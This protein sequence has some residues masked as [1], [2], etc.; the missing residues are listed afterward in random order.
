MSTLPQ[1]LTDTAARHGD[2]PAFKLDDTGLTYAELD[3]A[4]SRV[5]GLLRERG[6]QPG[7]RVGLMLPNVP[8]FP[9]IYY[10]ILRAGGVVV[11]MNV[12]LKGRE[13]SFYL[14]DPGAKHLFAWHDFAAAAE[15][16]AEEAGAE[17]IVVKPGE[18]ERLLADAPSTP[19]NA[20]RD[21]SDTAIILYTSGTT[22]TPKGAELTHDN[23]LRNAEVTSVTL[24]NATE[25]DVVLGALPLF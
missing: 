15:Q 22:G 16:G 20:E 10:G 3:A 8:Y 9:V 13:V 24:A 2:R 6:V 18:F 4:A 12:L 1:Q 17:A 19:G 25:E 23:L 11:P 5:A 21:G 14:T 7:D